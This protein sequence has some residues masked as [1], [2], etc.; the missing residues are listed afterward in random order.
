MSKGIAINIGGNLDE[1]ERRSCL[2]G[3]KVDRRDEESF[4]DG[5]R[6]PFLTHEKSE[7]T[8]FRIIKLRKNGRKNGLARLY[9]TSRI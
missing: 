1:D 6:S 7:T 2:S 4:L 9:L 3:L 8:P 5:M